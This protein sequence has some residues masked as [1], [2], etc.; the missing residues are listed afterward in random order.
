MPPPPITPPYPY[1][2]PPPRRPRP[3]GTTA[4][5]VIGITLGA[6]MVLGIVAA[7]A[8][9]AFLHFEKKTKSSEAELQLDALKKKLERY[10]AEN[11]RLP[12]TWAKLT[13]SESCCNGPDFKCP[14]DPT[15]WAKPPW[16]EIG[17]SIDS[18]TYYQL[19]YQASYDS[20]TLTASGDLN[21]DGVP[22][23]YVLTGSVVAGA[24]QFDRL[25]K[26]GR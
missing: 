4:I 9:P 5:F 15:L 25:Q 7:V 17:F 6:I 13:P 14:P 26:P 24:L 16:S 1:M 10:Y 2:T 3:P 11:H 20:V 21:C 18:P 8:I 19:S 22:E 23:E 12:Q